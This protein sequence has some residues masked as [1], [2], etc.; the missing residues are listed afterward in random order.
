MWF[1]IWH[2][3]RFSSLFDHLAKFLSLFDIA[4]HPVTIYRQIIF[5]WTKL[6]LRYSNATLKKHLAEIPR[7]CPVSREILL[8]LSASPSGGESYGR[9]GVGCRRASWIESPDRDS[10]EARRGSGEK[11]RCGS[12]ADHSSASSDAGSGHAA[13]HPSAI[14][15]VDLC[16]GAT[17]ERLIGELSCQQG[18]WRSC[19]CWR[20]GCRY[21]IKLGL[22]LYWD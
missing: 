1:P 2:R 18:P 20:V 21:G 7:P 4:V 5:S 8:S 14:L 9:L 19:G 10:E 13:E 15:A 3:K 17:E 11:T 16:H 6:P 22:G 12:R